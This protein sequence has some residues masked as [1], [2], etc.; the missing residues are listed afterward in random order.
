[1]SRHQ[2]VAGKEFADMPN[3]R[4][5]VIVASMA[6]VGVAACAASMRSGTAAPAQPEGEAQPQQGALAYA[7]GYYL[8][9]EIRQ[10]LEADGVQADTDRLI[11]G[12]AAAM[13]AQEPDLA[14]AEMERALADAH[15]VV[16]QRIT[17]RRLQEDP[18]FKA[19]YERNLARSQAF[20]E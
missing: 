8:G 3:R 17:E 16:Q 4:R 1:M 5:N 15:D 20:H 18:E 13:R 14:P 7:V 9:G 2:V 19:L 10:G 12:F 11:A 6:A